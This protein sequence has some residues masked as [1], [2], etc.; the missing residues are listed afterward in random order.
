M[1]FRYVFDTAQLPRRREGQSLRARRSR[2]WF[3]LLGWRQHVRVCTISID[4]YMKQTKS[5]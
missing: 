5:K 3:V 4:E 2:Q 1:K